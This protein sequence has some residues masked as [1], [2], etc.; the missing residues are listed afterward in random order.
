MIDRFANKLPYIPAVSILIHTFSTQFYYKISYEVVL[1]CINPVNIP[2]EVSVTI[3]KFFFSKLAK[4]SL[5]KHWLTDAILDVSSEDPLVHELLSLVDYPCTA[6]IWLYVSG[7]SGKKI[8]H[9][10]CRGLKN[11]CIKYDSLGV[12]GLI[13][14]SGTFNFVKS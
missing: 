2:I 4:I 10:W 12:T 8:S 14:F 5:K 11:S 6:C 7:F 3:W 1:H 9:W 13:S